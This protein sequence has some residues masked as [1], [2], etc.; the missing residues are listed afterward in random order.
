M[1]LHNFRADPDYAQRVVSEL[2]SDLNK[3]IGSIPEHRTHFS[4][5]I[6]GPLLIVVVPSSQMGSAARKRHL[7]QPVGFALCII[8]CSAD[9]RAPFVYPAPSTTLLVV[10]PVTCYMH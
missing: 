6:L 7:P 3:F 2:D 9:H 5:M 4:P 1:P 8:L 10:L